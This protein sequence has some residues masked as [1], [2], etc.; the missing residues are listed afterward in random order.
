[1]RINFRQGIV[2]VPPNF[3]QQSGSAVNL[4]IPTPAMATIAFA[5]GPTDYLHTE[6]LTV[7]NAWTGPFVSGTDYWL[8]W[9]ID[10]RT[11]VRT[12]GHTLLEPVVGATAPISPANDQHWFDTATNTMKVWNAATGTWQ[13]KIRVFAAK[14]AGGSVFVSMSVNSPAFE[15]TQVGSHMVAPARAGALVFDI[16]GDPVRRGDGRFFTTED[17]AVTGIAASS[18]VKIGSIVVDAVA[19]TSIPAYSVVNFVDFHQITLQSFHKRLH[20]PFGWL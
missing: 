12:F 5:D 2:R 7:L 13:R 8:Y 20:R 10:T 6:R 16:N 4:V 14:L 3:L 17:V 15:G 19:T 18:Q 1:M 11:G 9:D